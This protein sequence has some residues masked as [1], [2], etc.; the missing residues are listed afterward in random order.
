MKTIFELEEKNPTTFSIPLQLSNHFKTIMLRTLHQDKTEGLKIEKGKYPPIDNAIPTLIQWK[1]TAKGQEHVASVG[2]KSTKTEVLSNKIDKLIELR[3]LDM[4]ENHTNNKRDVIVVDGNNTS[5]DAVSVTLTESPSNKFNK[6]I[7]QI[8]TKE[9]EYKNRF[10]GMNRKFRFDTKVWTVLRTVTHPSINKEKEERI[11]KVETKNNIQA[12]FTVSEMKEETIESICELTDMN[13]LL[14]IHNNVYLTFS[15][16]HLFKA[17]P[18][19][20]F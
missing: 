2:G 6:G 11:F 12:E 19:E 7:I 8:F 20:C 15:R 13:H 18:P 14:I 9:N 1:H 3:Q 4:I 16:N 17:N 10:F 5:S